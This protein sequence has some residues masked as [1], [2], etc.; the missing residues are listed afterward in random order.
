[1]NITFNLIYPSL[2]ECIK[3]SHNYILPEYTGCWRLGCRIG[4]IGCFPGI[5]RLGTAGPGTDLPDIVGL[6]T[7]P[8]AD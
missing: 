3:K 4:H 6:D 2:K 8:A 5:V 7:A 1:L